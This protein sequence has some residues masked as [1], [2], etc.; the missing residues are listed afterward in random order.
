MIK[1]ERYSISI[2]LWILC[3]RLSI[4]TNGY[5]V[6]N[7]DDMISSFQAYSVCFTSNEAEML[8]HF[9]IL[10]HKIQQML[11]LW[12][13]WL[14]N[15]L[16]TTTQFWIKHELSLNHNRLILMSTGP[17]DIRQFWIKHE[18]SLN[19]NRLILMSTG[20]ND[21]LKLCG[22]IVQENIRVGYS[23]L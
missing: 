22:I 14:L 13:S 9:W 23:Y 17:N 19:H 4:F 20:P 1:G 18:L 5:L 3:F 12:N 10:W 11:H 7:I 21:I 8:N 2:K 15:R 6:Q 16:Y